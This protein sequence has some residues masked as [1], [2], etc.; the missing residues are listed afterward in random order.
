MVVGSWLM[1]ASLTIKNLM[2]YASYS[3]LSKTDNQQ[4]TTNNQNESIYKNR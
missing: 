2:D 3:Y 1:E 4:P